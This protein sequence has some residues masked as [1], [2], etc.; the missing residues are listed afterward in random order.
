M[1]AEPAYVPGM[2]APDLMTADELQH[3]YIPD[4][5]VQLVRGVLV[6]RE[7][8]GLRHAP[9][10]ADL[11]FRLSAHV[12]QADLGQVSAEAGSELARE[13]DTVRGPAGALITWGR[14]ADPDPAGIA[15]FP[16]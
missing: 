4:K 1:P 8:P 7:L 14:P 3:V 13:P 10:A 9:V 11:T 16:P 12:H 2:S 6:V 5:Q 15:D